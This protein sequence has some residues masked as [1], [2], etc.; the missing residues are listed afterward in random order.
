MYSLNS[1]FSHSTHQKNIFYHL[2][3]LKEC[4]F[5]QCFS[6]HLQP[7]FNERRIPQGPSTIN[8]WKLKIPEHI[9]YLIYVIQ[10]LKSLSKIMIFY[11]E[12]CD[13]Y[14]LWGKYILPLLLQIKYILNWKDWLLS[15][16]TLSYWKSKYLT[17]FWSV[18]FHLEVHLFTFI[19]SFMISNIHRISVYKF[20]FST[21]IWWVCG[22]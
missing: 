13:C 15:K 2:E 6:E 3:I 5:S 4:F 18:L 7:L 17:I 8:M 22:F 1:Y 21:K 12:L 19:C 16:W 10:Y 20:F 11:C 9:S 14:I